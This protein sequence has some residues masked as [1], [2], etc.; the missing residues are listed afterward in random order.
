MHCYCQVSLFLFFIITLFLILLILSIAVYIF[1]ITIIIILII[2]ISL[3]II[4]NNIS[5]P[6]WAWA[7]VFFVMA[8]LLALYRPRLSRVS[9]FAFCRRFTVC[10]MAWPF[11]GRVNSSESYEKQRKATTQNQQ[12][13]NKHLEQ[14][15]RGPYRFLSYTGHTHTAPTK[16]RLTQ[17]TPGPTF[18]HLVN[19]DHKGTV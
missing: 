15:E 5:P 19:P 2:I 1:F 3:L 17:I 9:R 14:N 4:H 13:E 16:R 11:S 10:P 8:G 18:V 6:E 12:N 7:Q